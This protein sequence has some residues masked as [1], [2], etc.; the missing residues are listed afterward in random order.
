MTYGVRWFNGRSCVG[1]VRVNNG[2][3]VKYYIGVAKGYDEDE[4]V[5]FITAFGTTFPPA[6]GKVLFND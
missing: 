4:D 3:E 1:I 6:A 2:Y 5:Q